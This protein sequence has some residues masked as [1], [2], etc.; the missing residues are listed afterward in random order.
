[1]NVIG[2]G[3][4]GAIVSEGDEFVPS[5]KKVVLED[6]GGRSRVKLDEAEG[7]PIELKIAY[8]GGGSRGWAHRLMR[9]LPL[10]P[11][12]TG[13]VRLYDIDY[14]AAR[15]NAR[16]ANWVMTHPNVV[17]KWRWRAVRTLAAAL[18]D[19]DFVFASILPGPIEYMKC[20]LDFPQRYGIFQAVGDTVGPGGQIRALRAIRD[21]M[22]IGEAV[23][24]YAPNAWVFNFTNPMTLCTRTLYEAF[25]LIKGFG[26]CHEVFGSQT[27]LGQIYAKRM[28]IP[29][30]SREQIDINVLGINHFTW[31]DRASYEGV[32]L[33]EVLREHLEQP[34]AI[35]RY[36]KKQMVARGTT[37]INHRQV[38]WDLFRRFGVLGAAGDRHLAEFVPW[39]LTDR[40]SCYRWGFAL[41]P[42]S[43]RLKRWRTAP[44][45]FRRQLRLGEFPEMSA[46]SEEFI[47]Q[48]LSLVG[49]TSLKTNVNLPNRGQMGNIPLGAVVETNAL[50][51]KDSVAPIASGALPES[52][53]T[54]VRRHVHNQE[55][56]LKGVISGD[57]DLTF[58]GFLNDPLVRIS[59]DDAW[60]LFNRMLDKTNYRFK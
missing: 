58:Q 15:F 34:G 38:S 17:S 40:D 8:I 57:K 49:K 7:P 42:Y 53:N 50:F 45:T 19:A 21:Y 48:M 10:C 46:S 55:T 33:L 23:G 43:Y 12:F 26:C 36:G 6:K 51:T 14:D 56:L 60:K 30:P 44:K 11:H 52:V 54:W 31:I 24:Q 39:Y 47:N 3:V 5:M 37:F 1:M 29:A 35:R 27:V 18:K 22:V 20:D 28:G 2:V 41:T 13:E 32:D 4:S 9:D 59:T 25:P 16:Y